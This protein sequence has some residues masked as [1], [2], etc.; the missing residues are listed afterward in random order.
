MGRAITMSANPLLDADEDSGTPYVV[1]EL[2]WSVL[3]SS[4]AFAA[5]LSD[6][7][8]AI[9]RLKGA[10]RWPAPGHPSTCALASL[11]GWSCVLATGSDVSWR[12]IGRAFSSPHLAYRRGRTDAEIAARMIGFHSGLEGM[13]DRSGDTGLVANALREGEFVSPRFRSALE[14][15][16]DEWIVHGPGSGLVRSILVMM[17]M[18]ASMP[19]SAN[20]TGPR[21]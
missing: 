20:V 16:T 3:F 19:E 15:G 6:A 12:D 10:H 2:P 4:D 11:E 13:A 7:S 8:R 1:P 21:R 18:A 9:G 17:S 5:A 14:R